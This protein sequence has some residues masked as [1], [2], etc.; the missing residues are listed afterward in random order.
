LVR[1]DVSMKDVPV[2]VDC[3][4]NILSEMFGSR[5]EGHCV[6]GNSRVTP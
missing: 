2:R 4:V 5:S 6:Q 1:K 3:V